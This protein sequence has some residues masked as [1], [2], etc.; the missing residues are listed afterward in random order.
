M[1]QDGGVLKIETPYFV[2]PTAWDLASLELWRPGRIGFVQAD[3][4]LDGYRGTKHADIHMQVWADLEPFRWWTSCDIAV[5]AVDPTKAYFV[6]HDARYY[7]DD[8]TGED[9]VA[10][11]I[12]VSFGTWYTARIEIDPAGFRLRY[13]LD[14]RLIASHVPADSEELLN[15]Y[16]RPQVGLWTDG[17]A[18]IEAMMDDFEIGE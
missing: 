2:E 3:L 5:E 1:R 12:P 7:S 15:A 6:C 16:L 13:Y 8:T 10:P 17:N 4:R 11:A 18:S 14:D 9:Y